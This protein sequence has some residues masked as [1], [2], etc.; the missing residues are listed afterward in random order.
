MCNCLPIFALR[1]ILA[2]FEEAG[3]FQ[4]VAL[5]RNSIENGIATS[6]DIP[7]YLQHFS[8]LTWTNSTSKSGAFLLHVLPARVE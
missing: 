8:H 3:I 4:L 1:I 7:R 6:L 2:K 5:Y